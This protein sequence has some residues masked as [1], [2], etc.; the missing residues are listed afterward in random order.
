MR[1]DNFKVEEWFNKYEYWA[2]YDL[3]DTCV[4]SLSI[5]ELFEIVGEKDRHLSDIFSRKLNYGDIHGSERLKNAICSMYSNQTPDNITITHGAIGANQLVMLSM[6][7]RGDK[8][9]SIIPTYQQHYSIPKSIGADVKLLFLKEENNW[10][11]DLDELEE[12][13]GDDTKIICMNNP[14]NPTG[15]VIPENMLIKITE[16]AEK[17][18]AYILCDEVY[19]GLEH[20]GVMS[21]SVADIYEK[22]I[23]TGSVSKVFSLAGLRL[24]WITAPD[25]VINEVNHQREYNTISVGILD[26]YFAS[27]AI[28]NKAKIIK[29]NLE[30]INTGK[31]I[32]TDWL[33]NETLV[34]C[35]IPQGG[36]TAFAGYAMNTPSTELCKKL[37]EETGVMILP[38]EC[39]ELDGYLRIGYGNNF[40]QLKIALEIFS[41]W[42]R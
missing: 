22:G 29:R 14:N 19:R 40:E 5:E 3:A 16:I 10:L 32:L 17:S 41:K 12:L 20:N 13:V 4:E 27:L 33:E 23:S 8:V 39:M 31:K 21:K 42:L 18:G 36:T 25:E 34:R 11:P 37:Q 6:V 38:G 15:A 1:I 35:V 7:E 28:E 24:G 9:V 2:K 26:D 30:K